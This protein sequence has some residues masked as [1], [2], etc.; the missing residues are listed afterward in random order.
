MVLTV[1][2]VL[3]PVVVLPVLPVLLSVMVLQVQQTLT[4]TL[5][6]LLLLSP[7]DLA[8][9]VQQVAEAARASNAQPPLPPYHRLYQKS[10]GATIATRSMWLQ[11]LHSTGLRRLPRPP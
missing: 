6:L 8:A 10:A 11:R 2:P 7:P 4:W 5:E 9:A 1:L 3:L